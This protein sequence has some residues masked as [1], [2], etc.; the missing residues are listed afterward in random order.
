MF[1]KK[2]LAKSNGNFVAFN[3]SLVIATCF[4]HKFS[5]ILNGVLNKRI[6]KLS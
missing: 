5:N 1:H 4:Y 6:R 2:Y 3:I